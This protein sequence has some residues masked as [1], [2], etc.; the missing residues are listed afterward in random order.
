MIKANNRIVRLVSA[1]AALVLPSFVIPQTALAADTV[2][3]EAMQ[4]SETIESTEYV[5]MTTMEEF[6]QV[7]DFNNDGSVDIA[8]AV[9]C[10]QA[11]DEGRLSLNDFEIVLRYILDGVWPEI[12]YEEWDLDC[13][14]PSEVSHVCSVMGNSLLIKEIVYEDIYCL[15]YLNDVSV[16]RYNISREAD[17]LAEVY[18]RTASRIVGITDD[19]ELAWAELPADYIDTPELA[20]DLNFD[21]YIDTFDII[22]CRNAINDGT[23][24]ENDM[25]MLQTYVLSG[26]WEHEITCSE[27]NMDV[28]E[29]SDSIS[30]ILPVIAGGRM[31]F[32]QLNEQGQLELIFLNN[33][34]VNRIIVAE[35]D[36]L[37]EV[38]TTCDAFDSALVSIGVDDNGKY[39]ACV[40]D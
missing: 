26:T 24:S 40:T 4:S 27:I 25:Y 22:A 30:R 20:Y 12:T 21:G 6:I 17:S 31:I 3:V 5:G 34:T 18:A 35:N 2:E 15:E 8:D 9:T 38:I 14:A 7:Y 13:L 10:N 33:T 37:S 1:M 23:L 28:M 36:S 11:V 32:K 16:V 19:G 29:P 39:A